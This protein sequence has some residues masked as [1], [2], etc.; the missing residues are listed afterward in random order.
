MFDA[1]RLSQQ[2]AEFVLASLADGAIE[3]QHTRMIVVGPSH[4]FDVLHVWARSEWTDYAEVEDGDEMGSLSLADWLDEVDEVE[5]QLIGSGGAGDSGDDRGREERRPVRHAQRAVDGA[6]D[7]RQRALREAIVEALRTLATSDALVGTEPL[8]GLFVARLSKSGYADLVAFAHEDG[9]G[10]LL[11]IRE[12]QLPSTSSVYATGTL[13][14]RGLTMFF[15]EKEDGKEVGWATYAFADMEMIRFSAWDDD[16]IIRMRGELFDRTFASGHTREEQGGPDGPEVERRIREHLRRHPELIFACEQFPTATDS[17][18]VEA[19]MKRYLA[20]NLAEAREV[21]RA[22]ARDQGIDA[23]PAFLDRLPRDA[24]DFNQAQASHADRLVGAKRYEQALAIIEGLPGKVRES[25]AMEEVR[26]LLSLGR[27]EQ[28]LAR[29]SE[30]STRDR[31]LMVHLAPFKAIALTSLGRSE[32]ALALI[33][34]LL[35]GKHEHV[36][37]ADCLYAKAHA[38]KERDS[39]AARALLFQAFAEG[40][41]PAEHAERDFA[42]SAELLRIFAR[43]RELE[44]ARASFDDA[45]SAAARYV[46]SRPLKVNAPSDHHWM[47]SGELEIKGAES[48]QTLALAGRM[49]F[50]AAQ[51]KGLF[52]LDLSTPVQ[53]RQV[54]HLASETSFEGAAVAGDF[55]YVADYRRGLKVIDVREPTAPRLVRAVPRYFADN[56]AALALG[57]GFIAQGG[58]CA[59]DIYA[60]PQPDEPV[61]ASAL[62]IGR[63]RGN[64]GNVNGLAARG[65]LLYVAAGGTGLVILDLSDPFRPRLVSQLGLES[66]FYPRSISLFGDVAFLMESSAT[67]RVDVS[68]PGDPRSLG[69]LPLGADALLADGDSVLGLNDKTT[70]RMVDGRVVELVPRVDQDQ[71]TR[72]V[73][74]VGCAALVGDTLLVGAGK[75]FQLFSL[76]AKPATGSVRCRERIA[77]LEPK[78]AAWVEEQLSLAAEQHPDFVVGLVMLERW[79]RAL[80]LTLDAP[81]SFLGL[82]RGPLALEHPRTQVDLNVL[83]GD[84]QALTGILEDAKPEGL[85][86]GQGREY[87]TAVGGAW[88]QVIASILRGLKS[89][90]SLARIAAG[91]VLLCTR[92]EQQSIVV[93]DLRHDDSKPW[94]PHRAK[95]AG[96]QSKTVEELLTCGDSYKHCDA[97]EA[98]A[99]EDDVTWSEVLRLAALGVWPAARIAWRLKDKED[100]AALQA[101]LAACEVDLDARIL[102]A[103]GEKKDRPEVRAVLE[104]AFCSNQKHVLFA[105]ARIL[106][107]CDDDRVVQAVRGLLDDEEGTY[108]AAELAA[109]AM[110]GIKSRLPELLEALRAWVSRAGR[111]EHRLPLIAKYLFAAGEATLPPMLVEQAMAEIRGEEHHSERIGIEELDGRWEQHEACAAMRLWTGKALA[112]WVVGLRAKGDHATS[113]YPPGAKKEP[114]SASWTYLLESAWPHLERADAVG[115]LVDGLI[116]RARP[117]A[118]YEAD[119]HLLVAVF[120]RLC[121]SSQTEDV[122]RLARAILSA[123]H[124]V[125]GERIQRSLRRDYFAARLQTGWSLLKQRKLVEARRIAQAALEDEPNDGQ[126]LFFDTRLVWLEQSVEASMALIPKHLEKL[127]D[128]PAGRGRLLNLMGCALDSLGR[129]AEALPWFQKA[130]QA[131]PAFRLYLANIAEA[132]HKTG[133]AKDALRYAKS[134]LSQGGEYAYARKIIAEVEG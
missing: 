53:P 73:N 64:R 51:T 83:V 97:V 100:E 12:R 17:A 117:G 38:L 39:A 134:A 36:D 19:W 22:I 48:V 9:A 37:V 21:V 72:S 89:S 124:E 93:V 15:P 65:H 20:C 91:R 121:A 129:P 113:F 112:D 18:A 40:R 118:Q 86:E 41:T 107:R 99:R 128:D 119:R 54:G 94:R 3:R 122:Q 90:P 34:S 50:V 98:K 6:V 25:E 2:I 44:V 57:D 58:S 7:Q 14:H 10:E 126:V 16:P 8:L 120:R 101:L 115:W 29:V 43:R 131:H 28:C 70:W 108:A 114:H 11:P 130:A 79:G 116:E 24:A 109:E 63:L 111:W 127:G 80:T 71:G 76:Q 56:Q 33:E 85:G 62:Q 92:D 84:G 95:V 106:D 74:G 4:R 49:A 59:L 66:E 26:C 46:E 88:A 110:E 68:D 105:A 52:A 30:L 60:L 27:L 42:G 125:Y 55:V 104:R 123:P 67:W 23:I 77:P 102:A 31:R 87:D 103:L 45:L 133:N 13:T 1:A 5:R 132:Y 78:V 75:S 35:D 81:R 96:R 61:H 47:L 82:E 69:L 32:E